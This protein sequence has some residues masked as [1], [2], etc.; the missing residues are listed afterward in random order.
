MERA[1][2]KA[3]L[4][5]LGRT[6]LEAIDLEFEL[7]LAKDKTVDQARDRA[8]ALYHAISELR[9]LAWRN[10]RGQAKDLLD[11]IHA[12]NTRLRRAIRAVERD[13][14]RADN[15]VKALGYLDNVIARAT[16]IGG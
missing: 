12:T 5:E 4:R 16:A 2:T 13:M 8:T 6:Y 11:D 3:V 15:I 10:W 7:R 1:D 14:K 9:V